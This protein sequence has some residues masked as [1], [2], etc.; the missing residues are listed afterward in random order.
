MSAGPLD[1]SDA[2]SE[3][4]S[5]TTAEKVHRLLSILRA[6]QERQSTRGRFILKG[7]TALNIFHSRNIPRLSVDLDLM[8]VGFPGVRAGPQGHAR[9]LEEITG[10]VKSLGY[11]RSTADTP[12]AATV[13]CG[14]RNRRGSIDQVKIDL[15]LLNRVTLL[16]PTYLRGPALFGA[17][18][19]RFPVVDAAELLG[20]KLTAVAYRAHP[21]DLF[22]MQVMLRQEWH[23]RPHAR[24]MYLAYSFLQDAEWR[25]LDYPTRLNVDY[26]ASLLEDVL[27]LGESAP[28]LSEIRRT[29]RVALASTDPPFGR[30]TPAEESMRVAL[31]G[32]DA[33][34]FPNLVGEVRPSK[35]RSLSKHPG[36]RW[37]LLQARRPPRDP[38]PRS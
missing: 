16:R 6:I 18:D 2:L 31:L 15:D 14:Y 22:D 11:S 10:V 33:L 27:R 21:R 9:V 3:G 36:L 29:A 30:A 25:R 37:R 38:G 26:R 5:E 7:G 23:L 34:A 12:A 17:D 20:Q 28:N 4:F 19:Y 1:V 13:R 8:V 32:G 24:Q 35:R